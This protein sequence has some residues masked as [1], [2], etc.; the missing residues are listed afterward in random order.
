MAELTDPW[1]FDSREVYL[2]VANADVHYTPAG[3]RPLTPIG[4]LIN[5]RLDT[6]TGE[7]KSVSVHL[8]GYPGADQSRSVI[9]RHLK[10]LG[11]QPDW[12]RGAVEQFRPAPRTVTP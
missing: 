6:D 11:A 3:K 5:Y 1:I 12:I 4:L 2:H 9:R 10:D 8:A 7:T